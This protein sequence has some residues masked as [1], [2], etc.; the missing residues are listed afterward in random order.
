[1]WLC[2]SEPTCSMPLHEFTCSSRCI[3]N[4]IPVFMINF[5]ITCRTILNILISPLQLRVFHCHLKCAVPTFPHY[6]CYGPPVP[7]FI[8]P[9]NELS[10]EIR[11]EHLVWRKN[12]PYLY[13]LVV[14]HGTCACLPALAPSSYS[15]LPPPETTLTSTLHHR[16]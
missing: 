2:R 6:T 16:L 1:M 3:I 4:F 12:S 9:G 10:Q 15:P 13:D 11:E 14:L 7:H 5:S 8:F